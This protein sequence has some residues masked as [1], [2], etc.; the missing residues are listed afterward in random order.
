MHPLYL[1]TR[2]DDEA[3]CW[4]ECFG[5]LHFEALKE[6]DKKEMVH[7]TPSVDHVKQLYDTYVVNKL[8]C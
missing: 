5:H 1:A 8:K 4:H 6:L 7:G 2:R 3:W